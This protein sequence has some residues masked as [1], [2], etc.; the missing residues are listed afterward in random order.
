MEERQYAILLGD[1]ED[2]RRTRVGTIQTGR[3]VYIR[4]VSNED[5]FRRYTRRL[6]EVKHYID[7]LNKEHETGGMTE[8]EYRAALEHRWLNVVVRTF[9]MEYGVASVPVDVRNSVNDVTGHLNSDILNDLI[10]DEWNIVNVIEI[11]VD[12]PDFIVG[13]FLM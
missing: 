6:D 2:T 9:V 8:A 11:P 5:E 12:R 7:N 1:E 4:F 13:E 3:Y 10:D